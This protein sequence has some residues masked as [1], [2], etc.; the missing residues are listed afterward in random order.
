MEEHVEEAGGMTEEGID[1][2]A[3]KLKRMSTDM[4][5]MELLPQFGRWAAYYDTHSPEL[6]DG[7]M[8]VME[9]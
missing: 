9:R 4:M 7:K 8:T 1:V 6:L 5:F 3:R 2:M